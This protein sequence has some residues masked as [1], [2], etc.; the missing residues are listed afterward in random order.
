MLAEFL[1]KIENLFNKA[2]GVQ[3]LKPEGEASN[4]FYLHNHQSGQGEFHDIAA[5]P[6]Q[7]AASDLTAVA[8][9]AKANEGAAVWYSRNKVVCVADDS[10]FR[11]NTITLTLQPSV[12][13]QLLQ[14]LET[15]QHAYPQKEFVKLLRTTFANNLSGN[16]LEI[17]RRVKFRVDQS[18]ESVV[19]HGKASIGKSVEAELTGAG[20]LPEYVAFNVP[21]FASGYQS[22]NHSVR[23]ALEP[24]A[25]TQTFQLIPIPG[26]VERV[27]CEAEA[28]I[29]DSLLSLLDGKDVPVYY[30]VP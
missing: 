29:H 26:E 7:H 16:L 21:A 25:A 12:Q 5:K 4:R 19:A 10:T 9:F 14:R 23:C 13:V 20:V 8:E 17:V 1:A 22:L 15:N 6:R 24:D 30:G 28:G 27:M 11:R 2:Q 18:G 3:V